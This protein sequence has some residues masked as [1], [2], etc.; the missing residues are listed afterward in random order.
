[1]RIAVLMTCFNRKTVTVECLDALLQAVVIGA[2]KNRGGFAIDIW[3]NNDGCTDGTSKAVQGWFD[4]ASIHPL[5]ITLHIISGSGSDYWCGGMR[6]AWKAA[7][8]SGVDYDGFLWLNDDTLLKEM[9]FEEILISNEAV[10]VGAVSDLSGQV[11][12]YGGYDAKGYFV[13]CNGTVQEVARMN[14]NV[15]WIPRKVFAKIGNFDTHW[16]HSFGDGDYSLLAGENGFKVLLTAH[17]VGM[18]QR[19]DK[20]VPWQNPDKP[21]FERLR[22]LY[23]PLGYAEPHLYFRYSLKHYGLGLAIKRFVLQHIH[24]C[25]PRLWNRK[26]SAWRKSRIGGEECAF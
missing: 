1:M 8:D 16:T 3:L 15:V 4:T 7:I 22:N 24:V 23:S 18:C 17:F 10:V 6:R 5:P 12:A 14:G 25:F 13:R 19:E 21:F 2:A 26:L 11:D 20:L 9:A